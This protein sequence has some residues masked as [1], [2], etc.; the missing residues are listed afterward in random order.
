MKTAEFLSL[1]TYL[2]SR[3]HCPYRMRMQARKHEHDMTGFSKADERKRQP[4]G[5]ETRDVRRG[6][7][8]IF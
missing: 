2:I 6:S 5:K 4:K 7:P 1:S 8:G 3:C